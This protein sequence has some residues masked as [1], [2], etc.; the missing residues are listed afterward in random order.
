MFSSIVKN[1][2]TDNADFFLKQALCIILHHNYKN[3]TGLT[4]HE[5]ECA[6]TLVRKEC[7]CT[8]DCSNYDAPCP[9]ICKPGCECP[10]GQVIMPQKIWPPK[11]G[12]P[13]QCPDGGK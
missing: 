6:P 2:Q 10:T 1:E 8:K 12:L 3:V 11:C 7:A 9:R 13:S 5:P 4:N